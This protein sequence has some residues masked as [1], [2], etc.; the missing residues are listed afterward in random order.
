MSGSV[1][2]HPLVLLVVALGG[3]FVAVAAALALAAALGWMAED[4]RR[5]ALVLG[6]IVCLYF[7]MAAYAFAAASIRAGVIYGGLG[8]LWGGLAW[9]NRLGP[10]SRSEE[11]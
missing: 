7:G 8:V 9:Y 1:I 6:A 4:R 10:G 5:A 11:S 2:N 3:P